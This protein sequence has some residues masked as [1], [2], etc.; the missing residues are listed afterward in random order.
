MSKNKLKNVS[1][2][3][4]D[5]AL[6]KARNAQDAARLLGVSPQVLYPELKR[7][8]KVLGPTLRNIKQILPASH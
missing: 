6:E 1:N 8:G 2:A 7:R 5:V 4:I 3:E